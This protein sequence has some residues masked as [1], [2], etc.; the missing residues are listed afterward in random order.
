MTKRCYGVYPKYPLTCDGP[1]ICQ[2][3]KFDLFATDAKIMKVA[4][5]AVPRIPEHVDSGAGPF[6]ARGHEG[7]CPT[8]MR[9]LQIDTISLRKGLTRS[10]MKRLTHAL[11]KARIPFTTKRDVCRLPDLPKK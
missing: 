3:G 11:R 5:K 2:D 10:E 7:P 4:R 9:D 1:T 6:C 8:P